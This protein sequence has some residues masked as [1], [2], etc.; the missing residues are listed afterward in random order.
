MAALAQAAGLAGLDGVGQRV[1]VQSA[2]GRAVGVCRCRADLGGGGLRWA[3]PNILWA[4]LTMALL[5]LPAF[6]LITAAY[7]PGNALK[8]RLGQVGPRNS[9][10]VEVNTDLP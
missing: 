1:P 6:V 3:Q 4:S 5:T 10:L 8:A 2:N 9:A 7:V